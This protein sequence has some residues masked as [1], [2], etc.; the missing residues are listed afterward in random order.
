MGNEQRPPE[1]TIIHLCWEA[2]GGR[3]FAIVTSFF[4]AEFAA[5]VI[6]LFAANFYFFLRGNFPCLFS[7]EFL[8]QCCVNSSSNDS[9]RGAPKT[10]CTEF[11]SLFYC[12]QYDKYEV[13]RHGFS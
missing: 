10:W 9:K 5:L 6:S 4:S 12:G 11:F 1:A 2:G 7:C 8:V 13:Y 3:N